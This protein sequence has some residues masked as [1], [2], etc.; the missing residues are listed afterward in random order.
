MLKI[1]LLMEIKMK[2]I[3][4]TTGIVISTALTGFVST[5][6]IA[7]TY[8][9]CAGEYDRFEV[10]VI[11]HD[12]AQDNLPVPSVRPYFREMVQSRRALELCMML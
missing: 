4:L 2:K 3:L 6:A 9:T 11:S 12:W 8:E 7:G 10:A 1:Y 5:Q